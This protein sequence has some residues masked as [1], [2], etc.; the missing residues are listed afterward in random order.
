[1]KPRRK[2]HVRPLRRSFA[3][4]ISACFGSAALMLQYTWIVGPLQQTPSWIM[5]PILIGLVE[6]AIFPWV[7]REWVSKRGERLPARHWIGG[8][9]LSWMLIT[10]YVLCRYAIE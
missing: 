1:M 5:V 4:L 2:P 6:A 7:M 10:S 3:F 8:F 9:V